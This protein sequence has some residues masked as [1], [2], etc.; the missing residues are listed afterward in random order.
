MLQNNLKQAYKNEKN[1]KKI[2]KVFLYIVG[3]ILI[4][5]LIL[6]IN[7]WIKSPG[8]ADPIT[9]LDGKMLAGSISTIEKIMLGGQEQYLIIRGADAAKPVMLF[10]HGGPGSPEYAFMKATNRAIENDFVMVYWEQRGAGKSYSKNIPAE[11]MNLAQFISDTRELSEYLAK[12]FNQEKIYLMGHS[13]GSF[14]GILTAYE[15]PELFHAYF[16]IGQVCYQYKGEYI[17]FEWTKEQALKQNNQKAINALSKLTFPDSLAGIDVWQ[18]FLMNER[19]YVT[20]FGGG[21]THEMTGMWPVV[22]MILNIKEYTFKEKM[23]FMPGSLFSFKYLW[24]DVI[25][26]NLFN[27]IDSMQVPVYIFQGKY[28]YQTPYSVA[29]DFYDQLKAP[30]KEFFTFENS[31]HSPIME[32]VEKFNSIVLGKTR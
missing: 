16:G 7:L 24:P 32:E 18:K 22:K 10:L 20:Q 3:G 2:G 19:N 27:D 31:A 28:D 29:K 30:R 25:N 17:S 23:N 14:L 12:R 4:I 1:K 6:A 9:G 13:W 8:K 11:S 26:K 5:I 21:V 15:Y